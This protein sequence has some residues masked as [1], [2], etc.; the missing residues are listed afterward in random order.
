M[1]AR[2]IRNATD[3]G[4]LIRE[5]RMAEGL[6]QPELALASGVGV[7]FVVDVERGKGTS[8]LSLALRLL[9][10]LGVDLSAT[11]AGDDARD[12]GGV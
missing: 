12:E 9:E 1:G 7:R 11:W 6:T 10:R 2:S 4:H 5:R 3:L 8:R